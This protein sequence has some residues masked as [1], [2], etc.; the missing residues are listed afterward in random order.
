MH[1]L[2]RRRRSPT[3]DTGHLFSSPRQNAMKERFCVPKLG[4]GIRCRP[5]A[6]LTVDS[7]PLRQEQNPVDPRLYFATGWRRCEVGLPARMSRG[8]W[9]RTGRG[10]IKVVGHAPAAHYSWSSLPVI[11]RDFERNRNPQGLLLH[12]NG[13]KNPHRKIGRSRRER[14]V[15]VGSMADPEEGGFPSGCCCSGAATAQHRQPRARAIVPV[16]FVR[17]VFQALNCFQAQ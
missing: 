13:W 16:A 11:K 9:V 7:F 2:G 1:L 10:G 17:V 12:G 8:N 14:P 15:W 6:G 4:T 5:A 3:L